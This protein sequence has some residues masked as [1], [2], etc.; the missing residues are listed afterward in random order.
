MDKVN[1]EL[2]RVALD[3]KPA[4]PLSSSTGPS[5]NA[6]KPKYSESNCSQSDGGNFLTPPPPRPFPG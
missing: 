3:S 5:V 2:G 6:K 1:K 4:R